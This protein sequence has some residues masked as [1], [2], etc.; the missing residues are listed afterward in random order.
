MLNIEEA[1]DAF[2]DFDSRCAKRDRQINRI[3]E[4]RTFLSGKQWDSSDDLYIPKPRSRRTVNVVANSVNSVTNQYANYPYKWYS[5]NE[6][7]DNVCDAFLKAGSNNRAAFDALGSSV[8]FGLGYMAFGSESVTDTDGTVVDVPALYSIDKVEN[9]LYDP[10]SIEIDGKDA[11][12]AAILEFRSKNYIK[13]KYGEE[14]VTDKGVPPVVNVRSNNDPDQM[15]IVTYFKCEDGKCTIYRMLNDKFLEEPV[16]LN[17][18]RVP[19]FPIY[20]ERTWEDDEIVWQGL[21]RKS[22]PVQKLINYAFTQL[23][24]RLAVAPKPTFMTNGE[25]IEGYSENWKY[26]QY[27]LN[28]LLIIND[29]SP[30][31]KIDITP[32]QRFDNGVKFDDI[33]GIISA[34]LELMSTITGVDPK[35]IFDNQALTATEV[36]YNERQVQCTTRHFFANLRD[37]FKAVGETLLQLLNYGKVTLEVIQGPSEYMQQQ[38][39]RAE[40]V[41]LAGLVPEQNKMQIVDGILLSHNDNP[42]LRNVFGA[43]HRVPEP[44]AMEQEAMQTVEQMKMAL[45]QKNQQIQEMQK[46]IE[47]YETGLI[48]QD[49]SIEAD[50]VKMQLKHNQDMEMEAF[51]SELNGNLNAQQAQNDAIKSQMELEKQAIQLDTTKVKAV[52]EIA[53]ATAPQ[54]EEVVY[55]DR[56]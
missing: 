38:V 53:K 8:A 21:V 44:T 45:D 43:I 14:W 2:R 19:V 24:E 47:R 5:A 33:T 36:N 54:K 9:V 6:E 51:K 39:A 32:P 22:A 52:A 40:L 16:Q 4:D 48:S 34:N 55:E 28:Q 27:N 30:D 49:K 42:V 10:D 3:K 26:S 41:Q 15:V 11:L 18:D 35:G 7:V 56:A 46:Q 23:Q 17:I 1:I 25:S 29:K 12:E 20:G 13:A 50:V 37:T 31:G